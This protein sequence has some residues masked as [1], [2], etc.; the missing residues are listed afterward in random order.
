MMFTFL[1][2]THCRFNNNK[3]RSPGHPKRPL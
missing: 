3:T 2:E 1:I